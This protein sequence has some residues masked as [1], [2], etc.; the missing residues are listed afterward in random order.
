VHRVQIDLVN[1]RI[2]ALKEELMKLHEARGVNSDGR[3]PEV[4]LRFDINLKT[5]N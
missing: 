5:S 3:D 1:A 4:G 2:H